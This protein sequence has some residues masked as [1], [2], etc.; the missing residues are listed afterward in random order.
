MS[1]EAGEEQKSH[2]EV[3]G[4]ETNKHTEEGEERRRLDEAEEDHGGAGEVQSP[5][6]MTSNQVSITSAMA[7]WRQTQ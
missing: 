5:P 7:K 3:D 2:G 4:E 6:S 1:N